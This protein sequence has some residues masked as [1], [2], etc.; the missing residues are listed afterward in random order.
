MGRYD[1]SA[2]SEGEMEPG[3]R[4][5][6]LRNRLGIK[7]KSEAD[8][9]EFELLLAAQEIWLK[10]VT[11]ETRFTARILCQMHADWLGKIYDWAGRYRN[12]ELSKGS[13]Q[14][15]PARLVA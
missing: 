15:P 11:D 3:S 7:C 4:G 13:F 9:V 10:R 5:R 1:A 12:V 6:V 8:Q 14:W 2:G